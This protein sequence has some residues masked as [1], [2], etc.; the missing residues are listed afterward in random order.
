MMLM[1]DSGDRWGLPT[2]VERGQDQAHV[3]IQ[4]PRS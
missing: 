2:R 4:D 1:A 3:H